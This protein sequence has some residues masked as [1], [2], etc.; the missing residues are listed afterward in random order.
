[1]DGEFVTRRIDDII[2]SASAEAAGK[3]AKLCLAVRL[4]PGSRLS[5]AIRIASDNEV[6]IADEQQQVRFIA[7]DLARQ[8]QLVAI[9]ELSDL[10]SSQTYLK[11]SDQPCGA[12]RSVG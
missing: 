8:A 3:D 12:S 9:K 10:S 11:F 2:E 4:G 6:E 7:D 5:E 1:M